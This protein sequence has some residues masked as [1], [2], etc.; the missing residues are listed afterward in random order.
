[1]QRV[2]LELRVNDVFHEIGAMSAP[3]KLIAAFDLFAAGVALALHA[4]AVACAL[5][6]VLYCYLMGWAYGAGE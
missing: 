3:W 6:V 1:M 4:P 5:V 2:D